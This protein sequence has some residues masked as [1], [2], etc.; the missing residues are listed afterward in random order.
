[1]KNH[2][3]RNQVFYGPKGKILVET[4][5]YFP[6]QYTFYIKLDGVDI[7]STIANGDFDTCFRMVKVRL[8]D[9]GYIF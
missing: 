3:P 9:E 7:F 2:E 8:K 4:M 5:E 1:M 6:N